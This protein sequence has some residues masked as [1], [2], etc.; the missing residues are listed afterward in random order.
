MDKQNIRIKLRA[1]DNKVLDQSTEEIVNTV[2]MRESFR[3]FAGAILEK[4]VHDWFDTRGLDKS[5][6]MMYAMKCKQKEEIPAVLHYNETS[7][8][9]TVTPQQNYHFYNLIEEFYFRTGVPILL[10]T[11]FNLAGWPI[12]MDIKQAIN[13]LE[14][15]LIEYL[16]IPE[17]NKLVVIKND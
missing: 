10:N 17:E 15:S 16:Y 7:R 14:S 13:T 1:Y 8:I 5:P 11:S 2:K 9:Q 6:F 3:P 4:Y 12:V